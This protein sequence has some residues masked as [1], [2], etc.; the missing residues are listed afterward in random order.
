V[1]VVE[2]VVGAE[3]WVAQAAK[4]AEVRLRIPNFLAKRLLQTTSELTRPAART[5]AR[6]F[7]AAARACTASVG[8]PVDHADPPHFATSLGVRPPPPLL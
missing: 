5:G 1:R 7:R 6:L 8:P 4:A 3:V 2:V